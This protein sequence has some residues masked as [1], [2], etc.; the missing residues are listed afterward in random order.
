MAR[1]SR[2]CPVSAIFLS[3]G[4]N[5]WKELANSITITE[6]LMDSCTAKTKPTANA[7][8]QTQN[9]MIAYCELPS[10]RTFAALDGKVGPLAKK[11]W[12]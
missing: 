2:N 9:S 8:G 3:E 6:G 1:L 10:Y 4:L 7:V 11:L 5:R 12:S